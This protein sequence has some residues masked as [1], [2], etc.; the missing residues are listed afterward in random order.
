MYQ[1][2]RVEGDFARL[3][4]KVYRMSSG[5]LWGYRCGAGARAIQS[6]VT[7]K[8]LFANVFAANQRLQ[9][10]ISWIYTGT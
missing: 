9:R 4:L 5:K 10:E 6:L 7:Y 8:A 1:T 3:L 2:N